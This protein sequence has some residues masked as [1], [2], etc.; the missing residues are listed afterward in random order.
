MFDSNLLNAM[1]IIIAS[2]LASYVVTI[3]LSFVG[4]LTSKTKTN[5]DDKLINAVKL[6]IR[7]FAVLFGFYYAISVYDLSWGY[8]GVGL[9]EVFYVLIVLL[10]GFSVSRFIKTFFDWYGTKEKKRKIN[11]TMFVFIRKV[12]SVVVYLIAVIFI[13]NNFGIEIQPL[14]AGLGIAGLAIA[15]GLQETLANLFAALFIVMDKSINIGDWIQLDDGTK[16]YIEDI[17]W[18]SVRIRTIGG[19]T[20]IVPNSTFVGQKISSY[21]YPESPFYTSISVGVSYDADLDFVEKIATRVGE[22][23][24][25]SEKIKT[26]KNNPIIRYKELADSSI[27]FSIILT[28][29]SVQ[30]E[31]KIKHALI[32]EVVKEFRKE[33]IEIP[34]PQRVVY[35]VKD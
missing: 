7:Y 5:L 6:P 22:N 28:V 10:I 20:V 31:G 21:D 24:I 29:D 3:L 14:L 23:V 19:N 17:S 8:K 34:Y 2:L 18:R 27:N 33:N 32:K 16:A 25:K 30:N 1:V 12:S 15:L 4:K 26:Q 9:K 35:Q 13:L 11:E